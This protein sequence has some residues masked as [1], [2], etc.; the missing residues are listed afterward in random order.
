MNETELLQHIK[1]A[2]GDVDLTDSDIPSIDLYLDQILSLVSEKNARS[3]PRYQERTLTKTMI[4]NYSKSGLISP[5][6]GKKYSRSQIVEMLLVYALK[7]TLSIEEIKRVLIGIREDCDFSGEDIVNA[8]HR[9]LSL[10]D[11]NRDR[12][13]DTVHQLIKEDQLSTEDDKDFFLLLLDMLSYSAYLK[14][15]AQ[16][17]L[18]ARYVDPEKREQIRK[19]REET[20]KRERK[21]REEA[22]KRERKER[23]ESEKRE[24]K[25]KEEAE[26]E[27]RRRHDAEI[28]ATIKKLKEELSSPTAIT[29][30]GAEPIQ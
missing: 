21:E 20:E 17:L 18:E 23:E 30:D 26:K 4:N 12:A 25:D 16:E 28:K 24:R 27:E 15:V 9:F 13:A 10:K 19:E 1:A 2:V 5:I 29:A 11:R 14:A 3:T 22:E 8:Y 7:N 6:S